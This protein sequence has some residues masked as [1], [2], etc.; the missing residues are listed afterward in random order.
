MRWGSFVAGLL[1]LLA[2]AFC[3]VFDGFFVF[4]HR[5]PR[6]AEMSPQVIPGSV[7]GYLINLDRSP[8]RLHTALPLLAA[9]SFPCHR[10]AAID[11]KL[12]TAQDMA[13]S[14]DLVRFQKIMGRLPGRGEVACALSHIKAW[15]AFLNSPYEHAIIFEDDIDF[16]PGLLEKTVHAL[17]KKKSLW[18]ICNLDIREKGERM[19]LYRKLTSAGTRELRMYYQGVYCGDAYII[20]RRAAKHLVAKALPLVMT[21]EDYF[22]RG[23]EFG[24]RYTAL[25]PR[26]V[27]QQSTPSV[28]AAQP[29]VEPQEH[30]HVW[31][32]LAAL[33]GRIY[34]LKTGL[35]RMIYVFVS[36]FSE[37]T[38][39]ADNV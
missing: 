2:F 34:R 5:A 28:L 19:W 11:G 13:V 32:R 37:A 18:D 24:L 10:V 23:W 36:R 29:R 30:E 38:Q 21:V 31:P 35:A 12:M 14:V 25:F 26:L 20:N 8:H 7:G 27:Y 6:G 22:A 17:V 1:A 33:S 39:G 4:R 16:D 3:F 15:R 9:L